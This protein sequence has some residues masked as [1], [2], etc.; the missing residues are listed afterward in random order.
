MN[1]DGGSNP[2][3]PDSLC[4]QSLQVVM[5]D[6]A[7]CW[8]CN[9]PLSGNVRLDAL[10]EALPGTAA[11]PPVVVAAAAV[12]S[13]AAAL[14]GAVAWRGRRAAPAV[15]RSALVAEGQEDAPMVEG[16]SGAA[17]AP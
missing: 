2:V 4:A 3:D 8:R 15:A 6:C 1:D 17:S 5:A 11:G 13:L 7:E 10:P 9:K 16:G 14:A 12:A